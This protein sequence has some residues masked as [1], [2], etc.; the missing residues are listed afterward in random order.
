M[1]DEPVRNQWNQDLILRALTSLYRRLQGYPPPN[2][3]VFDIAHTLQ[4]WNFVTIRWLEV[5]TTELYRRREQIR[6]W[7]TSPIMNTVS[8]P[9]NCKKNHQQY[10]GR[11]WKARSIPITRRSPIM[12]T[13]SVTSNCKKNHQQYLGRDWKA[14]SIPITRRS[15][16]MNTVS[17]PSN[18][19]KNH[20]QYLGRDWTL[21]PYQSPKHYALWLSHSTLFNGDDKWY[22]QNK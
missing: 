9:S 8:V 19:K 3:Y 5:E 14:R 4:N 2:R 17:V 10:L 18:C 16:N 21:I 11:D 1:L 15:P 12:N 13:V 22:I 7:I 6:M 20:Q